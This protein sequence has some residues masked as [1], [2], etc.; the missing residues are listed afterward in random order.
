[1]K[2]NLRVFLTLG[3]ALLL[4]NQALAGAHESAANV[5]NLKPYYV[6][7]SV[8]LGRYTKVL[9]PS[10]GLLSVRRSKGDGIHGR[11]PHVLRSRHAR[12]AGPRQARHLGE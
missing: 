12:A 2:T 1:M 5:Q 9:P 10:E 6:N 8:D 4:S 7:E 3:V 11:E